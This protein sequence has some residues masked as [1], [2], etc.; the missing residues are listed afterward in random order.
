[1]ILAI[2][3]AAN[4]G[5]MGTPVGTPPNAIAIGQLASAGLSISFGKWMVLALPGV[6]AL[7]FIAWWL[8]TRMFPSDTK[9]ISLKIEGEFD[10]SREAYIFYAVFIVT[11]ILWMT[12]S[13]H[14]VT[15]SIVGFL[16]VVVLL[17]TGVLKEKDLQ[18]VQWHVLWL[19]AGGIAL[20]R[21]IVDSGLD[22]WVI[23]LIS[24]DSFGS[25]LIIGVF[26][27]A[28]LALS[29]VMSN[30]ASANLLIPLGVS[31]AMS[32]TIDVDPLI[33]GFMIA[34]G[35]SL[36][37]A[38]PIS[39]PTNAVAYSSGMI[40]TSDMAKTGILIGIIGVIIYLFISPLLWSALGVA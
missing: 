27:L 9:S 33:V 38:L 10:R 31:L 15:S 4:I 18:N 11:I 8:I 30:S 29:T 1:M 20:G 40:K 23:D 6:I 17:V 16:P 13:F 5:G 22:E 28:A 21:G 26:A 14:G 39:T 24:W 7:L 32:S 19:I 3:F 37:M 35:A 36:A 2:P 12:E 34:I 25:T